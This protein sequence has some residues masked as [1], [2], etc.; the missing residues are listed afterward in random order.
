MLTFLLGWMPLVCFFG[1]LIGGEETVFLFAVFAS[2]DYYPVWIVFVFCFLGIL[3]ADSIW[4]F[5]GRSS[6]ISRLKN[7]RYFKNHSDKAKDFVDRKVRGNHF[8][9]LMF[10]KF[11]YGLRIVTI[12]YLGRRIKFRK[13]IFYNLFIGAIWTLVIVSLGWFAGR[14]IGRLWDNYKNVQMIIFIVLIVII[15]FYILK[16]ILGK[17]V[18]K[19]VKN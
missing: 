11:L 4:F 6:I 5:V 1:S 12:M 14:G 13:F 17:V 10:T 16:I 7:I 8:V 2:Q 9:L 19:W 3:V 15:S 18:A